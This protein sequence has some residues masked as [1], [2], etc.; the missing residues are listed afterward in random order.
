VDKISNF[1]NSSFATKLHTID[2]CIVENGLNLKLKL[3]FHTIH[4]IY[5]CIV[6]IEFAYGW[7]T[8]EGYSYY[9]SYYGWTV[10]L[11][12]WTHFFI[13]A[14]HPSLWLFGATFL[15]SLQWKEFSM[16]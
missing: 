10:V 7:C 3:S 11:E 9:F 6:E 5:V 2:V 1:N 4:T 14:H 16:F 8:W 12:A 13:W 15:A